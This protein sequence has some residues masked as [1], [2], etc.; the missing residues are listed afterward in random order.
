M[1]RIYFHTPGRKAVVLDRERAN[2]RDLV[3]RIALA[4]IG[5]GDYKARKQIEPFLVGVPDYFKLF[6]DKRWA[7]EFSAW[8]RN[9]RGEGEFVINGEHIGAADLALNT[10]IAMQSPVMSLVAKIYGTCEDWAFIDAD[11]AEWF[12]EI[13]EMGLSGKVLGP[14][15]GW[16]SVA[17][18]AREVASGLPGPIV[19]SESS[20]NSFPNCPN[21]DKAEHWRQTEARIRARQHNRQISP[22]TLNMYFLTA[23]SA[24]DL[25]AER[26]DAR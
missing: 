22:A 23:V 1:S 14:N 17:E 24:F 20:V 2:M 8:F 9:S 10:V 7:Q 18:L 11:D 13:I 15:T 5:P 21:P 25:N 6:D 4:I 26:A 16:E 12:A 3:F 19:L